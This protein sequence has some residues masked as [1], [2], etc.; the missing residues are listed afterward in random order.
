MTIYNKELAKEYSKLFYDYIESKNTSEDYTVESEMRHP[1]YNYR[2][3]TKVENSNSFQ[4]VFGVYENRCLEIRKRSMDD[5]TS[6]IKDIQ[7]TV[8]IYRKEE[9]ECED[10]LFSLIHK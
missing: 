6:I 9:K 10:L 3:K 4:Q 5:V 2:I 7:E 8:D 1:G